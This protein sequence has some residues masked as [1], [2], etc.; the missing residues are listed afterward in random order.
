MTGGTHC[1]PAGPH[2]RYDLYHLLVNHVMV[3]AKDWVTANRPG[4][5]LEVI[6][7]SIALGESESFE[8]WRA[9]AAGVNMAELRD[10]I[11]SD[12]VAL[13]LSSLPAARIPFILN[14]MDT[15]ATAYPGG[16]IV[17]PQYQ[18]LAA[19]DPNSHNVHTDDI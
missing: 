14:G 4:D 15:D 5:E 16:T 8:P 19:P 10:S 3:A 9:A 1:V 2:A 7:V 11:R 13:G 17:N 6:D 12:I 18:A